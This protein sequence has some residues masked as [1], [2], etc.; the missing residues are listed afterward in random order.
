MPIVSISANKKN[1]NWQYLNSLV[2]PKQSYTGLQQMAPL[3]GKNIQLDSIERVRGRGIGRRRAGPR[4]RQT[5]PQLVK[6]MG[7]GYGYS[8][9]SRAAGMRPVRIV[10]L[11]EAAILNKHM[12]QYST[13]CHRRFMS[14][15]S[16]TTS[17]SLSVKQCLRTA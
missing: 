5:H 9:P 1:K 17:F 11:T 14:Y 6:L 7:N 10:R 16:T 12:L 15:S 2:S 13:Y 4:R 8:R 3:H